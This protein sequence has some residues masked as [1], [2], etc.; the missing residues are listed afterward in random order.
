VSRYLDLARKGSCEFAKR[1]KCEPVATPQ[2]NQPS[3]QPEAATN[4][5]NS[6]FA[7]SQRPYSRTLAALHQRCPALVEVGRWRQCVTDAEAFLPTWGQQAQALGWTP[8]DLFGLHTPP[9]NPHPSYSRLSRYDET[10]LLW[11]LEGRQ[12]TALSS[13]TAAIQNPSR[14]ITKFRLHNRPALGSAGDSLDD[15]K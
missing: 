3:P 15:L 1:E 4:S 13:N 8:R 7:S 12:V 10:G 5:Q 14:S 11:L 9:E 2:H 6:H